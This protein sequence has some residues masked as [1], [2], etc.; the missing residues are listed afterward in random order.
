[1]IAPIGLVDRAAF[2][3]TLLFDDQFCRDA[4][5]GSRATVC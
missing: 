3:P 1:M 2:D 4:R 5:Q